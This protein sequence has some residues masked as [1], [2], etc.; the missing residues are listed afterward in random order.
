MRKKADGVFLIDAENAFNKIN[1]AVALWNCQFV[2][3]S[4]KHGLIN[5]YRSP[6]RIFMTSEGKS[7]EFSS[8]EG[9]TQGCPLAMAMF[10]I[11]LKP[12]HDEVR[13]LCKQVW[14]ADDGTGCDTFPNM[15]KLYD[16]ILERG[17]LYGYFMQP[18]KCILIVK[19]GRDEKAREF[20]GKTG[21]AMSS[22]TRHL[23]AVLG[24]RSEKLK[25]VHEKVK[26]WVHEMKF[27]P[28]LHSQNL[29]LP[30]QL[31]LIVFKRSGTTSLAQFPE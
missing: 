31:S 19:E 1:R 20:F 3:P 14:F 8:Q 22:G 4:L 6:A 11:A 13:S 29:T 30:M 15:R 10:A 7:A 25:F 23:G 18:K 17:P 16:V 21:V 24:S 2:C 12:L 9:T 5:F 27:G 26:D 28:K